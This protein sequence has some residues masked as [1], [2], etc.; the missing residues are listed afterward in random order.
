MENIN[1][2]YVG[3]INFFVQNFNLCVESILFIGN[4]P[5]GLKMEEE[6]RDRE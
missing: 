5:K 1:Y 6:D 4:R 2:I 3:N